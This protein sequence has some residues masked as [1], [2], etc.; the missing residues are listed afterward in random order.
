M[1]TIRNASPEDKESLARIYLESRVAHF[2]WADRSVFSLGDFECDSQDEEIFVACEASGQ[3]TGFVSVWVPESFVHLL[4]VAPGHEGQG[5][6][7]KLLDHV[8]GCLPLPLRLKCV[9]A[10]ATALA[11]YHR[12]GWQA[13]S[14]GLDQQ[15]RYLVLEKQPG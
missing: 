2:H 11:F 15:Q 8:A 7:R 5:I 3:V 9:E 13:V 12:L 4:F 14:H 6:G 1:I 10:N